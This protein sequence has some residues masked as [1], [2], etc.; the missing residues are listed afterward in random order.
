MSELTHYEQIVERDLAGPRRKMA[1]ALAIGNLQKVDP[2][3]LVMGI[4]QDVLTNS[5]TALDMG[6]GLTALM[7]ELTSDYLKSTK[8]ACY[9]E[10]LE[11]SLLPLVINVIGQQ[12]VS[13]GFNPD[14]V[15]ADLSLSAMMQ[16][17]VSSY[18][19]SGKRTYEVT[20][21]L[22]EQLRDTELRGVM[23]EDIRLPYEALYIVIP[24]RAGLRVFN[25]L[26]GWHR[27]IGVY[28]TEDPNIPNDNDLDLPEAWWAGENPVRGWRIM[29]IG[30]D[31]HQLSVRGDDAVIYFR[32][33]LP[34]SYSLE[35][36]LNLTMADF[37]AIE[38]HYDGHAVVTGVGEMSDEWKRIFHW[39]MNVVLYVTHIEPGEKWMMNDEAK[40]LW[41][42]MKKLPKK[43]GKREKLKKRFQ[44]LDPRY[45]RILGSKILV[46]RGQSGAERKSG[47]GRTVLNVK[48]RVAGH[49]RRV[50]HGKGRALR[51]WKWI[52]PYWKFKDGVELSGKTHEV[53]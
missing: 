40:R 5:K 33:P 27:C 8:T 28:V 52:A 11:G 36:I 29:A 14:Q 2:V 22:A 20:P 23:A 44:S 42:R 26:S 34:D 25:P 39:V 31:K 9:G 21:G 49:W 6:R 18:E 16:Y 48:T 41:E 46:K 32:I 1:K 4:V 51:S 15:R 53:K 37:K 19:I 38:E 43:S 50:V 47:S 30:E 24:S 13:M 12:M 7:Q 45:R 3:A 10:F 35:D 17:H